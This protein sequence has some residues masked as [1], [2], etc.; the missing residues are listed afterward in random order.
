MRLH[1][2]SFLRLGG[3]SGRGPGPHG[4]GNAP[5]PSLSVVEGG[6]LSRATPRGLPAC[7]PPNLRSLHGLHIGLLPLPAHTPLF[8]PLLFS[9][10]LDL[11]LWPSLALQ[12]AYFRACC[13]PF[14]AASGWKDCAVAMIL[15]VRFMLIAC[16]VTTRESTLEGVHAS[17][18]MDVFLRALSRRHRSGRAPG[19]D[20][21][22]CV[23]FG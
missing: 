2:P 14:V 9:L 5:L 13:I 1:R 20:W 7:L 17:R 18:R 22:V 3:G 8:S 12:P 19:L 6:P 10:S 21:M 11:A 23:G 15:C 16:L 4:N